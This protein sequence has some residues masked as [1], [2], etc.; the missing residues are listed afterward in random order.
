VNV[1][2]DLAP[3]DVSILNYLL[4][5]QPNSVIAWVD[6]LAFGDIHDLAYVRLEYTNPKVRGYAHLSWLDPRKT[7]TVTVVGSEKMAIYDDLAEER[8]RIYDRGLG[9]DIDGTPSHERP[10][11]Y[12]YGDMIAPHI[13][14]DEP[15]AVQDKHFI[16]SIR[17]HT[18][19]ETG[20][21]TGL[22]IVAVLEALQKSMQQR[23]LVRVANSFAPPRCSNSL[24]LGAP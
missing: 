23:R 18:E 16:D 1:V 4:G 2:W 11:I 7:R 21:A 19:P 20:W 24:L 14:P 8:L 5:S 17:T 10:P 12:R 9:G 15:L 6:A 22:A 13:L 3:H